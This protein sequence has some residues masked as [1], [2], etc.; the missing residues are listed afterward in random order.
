MEEIKI[1][2]YRDKATG[3]ISSVQ[4]YTDRKETMEYLQKISKEWNENEKNDRTT[5][6]L[7]AN[8]NIIEAVR[9][10]L[11][12]D[13]AVYEFDKSEEVQAMRDRMNEIENLADDI[14]S[15]CRRSF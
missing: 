6:I 9:F 8:N 4:D 7:D 15:L 5:E 10:V 12:Q 11:K 3:K 1:V 14:S 13:K 2:I